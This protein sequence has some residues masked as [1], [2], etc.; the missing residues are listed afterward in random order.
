MVLVGPFGE[1][2]KKID[3]MFEVIVDT[4]F[5]LTEISCN[6]GVF[7]HRKACFIHSKQHSFSCRRNVF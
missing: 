2:E 1:R 7:R 4:A 5:Q 6:K 3:G